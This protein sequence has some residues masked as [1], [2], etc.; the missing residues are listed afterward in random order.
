ML[1]IKSIV[2]ALVIDTI[3]AMILFWLLPW[4]DIQTS[5]ALKIVLLTILPL[6]AVLTY[7]PRKRAMSKEVISPAQA[8]IGRSGTAITKLDP[9][10]TVRI[11]FE[12]WNAVSS[13]N[14]IEKGEPVTVLQLNGLV[15]TVQ[16]EKKPDN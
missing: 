3:M 13:S 4:Q 14:A 1:F 2:G 7:I 10:G 12:I 9:R 6:W 5:P 15:L 8:M 16:K 11:N